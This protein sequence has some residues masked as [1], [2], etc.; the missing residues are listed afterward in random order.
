MN[1]PGSSLQIQGPGKTRPRQRASLR[2]CC[3]GL[4]ALS[5]A[6]TT[7]YAAEESAPA[8]ATNAP[9]ATSASAP[10]A[11]DKNAPAAKAAESLLTPEQM[12]EG[13]KNTYNNWIELSAGGFIT[14]GNDASFQQQHQNTT[15]A[16]G[17]IESLHYQGTAGSNTT[18][19]VD[20]RSIFG[21]DD[22]DITLGVAR[23]KL[24][25]MRFNFSQ[26]RTWSDG[27]GG[28]FP[29]TG[30]YYP[31]SSDALTLDRGSISF[32]AGL[33]LD[34]I[35]K[36]TFKYSHDYRDGEKGSTIW[37]S[38]HPYPPDTG[39]TRSIAPS[40]YDIDESRDT[41]Q[42]DATHHI[43]AT[44]FGVGLRYETGKL[45]DALKM[46]QWPGEPLE[47]KIT[48][49]QDTSYD[50]FSVHGFSE[51]WLKK[52]LLLS[53][54]FSYSDL[55]NNLSGSRIYGSDFDVSYVPAAQ[56]LL[57]YTGLTGDSHLQEYVGNVNLF[58]KPTP[59]LS[60]VP[61][62]RVMSES[63]DAETAGTGTFMLNTPAPF[64]VDSSRGVIDVRERLD[65]RYTAITNWVLFARGEWTEG[66]GNLDEIGG[67]TRV[68][69]PG[70]DPINR[71]T[72]D[73]RFFQKY[74]AGARWYL[75]RQV[76][77]D[78]GGYYKLNSYDYTHNV[79]STLNNSFNRYPAY[80]V[81]QDFQTY[82]GNVRLTL[83]PRPNLT[84]ATRYEYQLSTIDT[85]P[86]PISGLDKVESSDMTT[87][88]IAEDIS[89][90]PLPRLSLQVGFNY[91]LSETETPASDVTQA[92]LNAQNNYW[93]LNFSSGF[94]LD[95]KTDLKLGY[96]YYR[97]NDYQDNS[98]VGLPLGAGGQEHA[99]TATL[100]RR[101][102]ER[103]RVTLR[104]GFFHY[105]DDLYG[106][107]RDFDSHLVY[108]SLQYRF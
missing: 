61:S 83:R 38:T 21:S 55:D 9:A 69:A 50:L 27:D 67:L 42:L 76:I 33:T 26:F 97:A 81:M 64:N 99:V 106:G 92:I 82:D 94:V 20:G 93:S 24:G 101:L 90:A 35:P 30:A 65:V 6:A 40:F 100:V 108:S 88:I 73:S 19:T 56:N 52:N 86:D 13:G 98:T 78:G 5:L 23:E 74:S 22:Y 53:L 25:Y 47:R 14:S 102:T 87:H 12:F 16:F 7:I 17:G 95:D 70:V 46:N 32:E 37:G 89:W 36:V 15:G 34:N 8:A 41:F 49:Q 75:S 57:G 77:L 4:L 3:A 103:M 59:F 72:D 62:I 54:G 91:V 11:D 104:Y 44:D 84:L 58:Y 79:D 10:T 71:Q 96:F 60:I 18:F 43:K 45:N 31:L 66:D 85:Q 39:L 28:Y 1:H 107:Y 63:M 48:D 80:L 105:T 68:G 2:W 51:T 29:P